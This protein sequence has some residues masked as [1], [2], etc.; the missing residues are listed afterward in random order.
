VSATKDGNLISRN[1]SPVTPEAQTEF[2]E[3]NVKVYKPNE[4]FP[5][6]GQMSQYLDSLR[7][8][9]SI[10]IK[11]PVGKHF[12]NA[13]SELIVSDR[14]GPRKRQCPTIAMMAGGTGITPFY[15]MIRKIFSNPADR[16]KVFLLF[17]NQT[18]DDIFLRQE[19]EAIAE[20]SPNFKLWYTL[21]RP[22]EQWTFSSGFIDAKM[23]REHLWDGEVAP[24]VFLICGPPPM[25]DRACKPSLTQLGVKETDIL[26]WG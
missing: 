18:E 13:P 23:I 17:A 15:A 21:D 7:I 3:V 24:S 14:D 9:D 19:L 26:V 2:F 4:R 11:G 20:K 22:P 6:G 16:T 8:G 12:Y 5:K 25:I 1:Y 10:D